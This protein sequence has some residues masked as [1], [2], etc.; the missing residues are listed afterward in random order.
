MMR[1]EIMRNPEIA[2]SFL[3][4]CSILYSLMLHGVALWAV[5]TISISYTPFPAMHIV[6]KVERT[7]L[8]NVLPQAAASSMSIPATAGAYLPAPTGQQ[9][10]PVAPGGKTGVHFAGSQRMVSVFP[11][12]TN[13]LQTILEPDLISPPPLIPLI[14]SPNLL[15]SAAPALVPPLVADDAVLMPA[16]LE[17][18]QLPLSPLDRAGSEDLVLLSVAPAKTIPETIPAGEMRG[19]FSIVGPHESSP[20]SDAGGPVK[21]AAE[22]GHP[23][24]HSADR[25]VDSG[26]AAVRIPGLTIQGGEQD[27]GPRPARGR[28]ENKR[29]E[30]SSYGL[31]VVSSGNSG[32]GLEDFGVFSDEP[33]FTVYIDLEDSQ[34]NALPSWILQ[35]A[36]IGQASAPE[37][38]L[39]PPL[40]AARI[41]PAWPS[42]L[43]RRYQNQIVVVRGLIDEQGRFQAL[44]MLQSPRPELSTVL[45]A[46]LEKWR[47]AAASM[48]GRAVAVKILLGV[49]IASPGP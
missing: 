26:D 15:E 20:T 47:F 19:D 32:G 38:V 14:P 35:Y 28:S 46:T 12:P 44:H 4:S 6:P 16:H 37:N 43:A 1:R 39:N 2:G 33:V 21:D 23:V 41:I 17:S 30:Q 34:G 49:P 18:P 3:S 9:R 5:A 27:S 10:R 11:H 48:S 45:L 40:P 36:S 13:S 31:T 22:Q 7:L 8:L 29:A 24:T 42:D 25:P